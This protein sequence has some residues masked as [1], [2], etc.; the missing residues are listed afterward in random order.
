MFTPSSERHQ[1]D[2]PSCKDSKS[3]YVSDLPPSGRSIKVEVSIFM[4]TQEYVWPSGWSNLCSLLGGI[5]VVGVCGH[6]P[7]HD[8]QGTIGEDT[9]GC[10]GEDE[11]GL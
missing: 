8:Q 2:V 9:L 1:D 11:E 3:S 6:S 5:K 4:S 7:S 10:R